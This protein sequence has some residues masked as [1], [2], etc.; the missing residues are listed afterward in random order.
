MPTLEAFVLCGLVHTLVVIPF[1]GCW[2][3]SVIVA[4]ACFGGLTVASRLL[5]SRLKQERWPTLLNILVNA[6]LVVGSFD[7]GFRV[8]RL[9]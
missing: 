5:A 8:D 2:S 4:F 3:Y 7:I 1:L 9:L 6:G